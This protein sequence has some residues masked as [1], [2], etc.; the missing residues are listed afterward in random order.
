MS[1]LI[2]PWE[3][4]FSK[5]FQKLVYILEMLGTTKVLKISE[6]SFDEQTIIVKF[7]QIKLQ[8]LMSFIR[9]AD[10]ETGRL[11]A[12]YKVGYVTQADSAKTDCFWL[13]EKFVQLT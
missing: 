6:P 12:L 2:L 13:S 10:K 3:Q 11:S 7:L 9:R 5:G 8:S 1:C 4:F